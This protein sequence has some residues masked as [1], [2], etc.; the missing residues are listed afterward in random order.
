MRD[1]D[2]IVETV[3]Y[4]QTESRRIAREQCD[5][6]GITAT[7]LNIIKLLH[8]IGNLSL[9]Q[10]SRHIAAKNSTVTGIVDRM[11]DADLVA[12]N[13]SSEDRRVWQIQLTKKGQKIAAGLSV[14]PWDDLRRALSAL[15]EAEKQTLI[16]ILRKVAAHVSVSAD[17]EKKTA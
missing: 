12:R 14:A 11:V 1:L 10:L 4:L 2:V 7:Q 8:E 15:D 5:A 16:T 17:S 13:Q 9:S 3:I 6:F